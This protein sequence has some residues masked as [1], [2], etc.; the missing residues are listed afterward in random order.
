MKKEEL[1]KELIKLQIKSQYVKYMLLGLFLTGLLLI[2]I[3][4]TLSYYYNNIAFS[5]TETHFKII[6][7]EE[8]EVYGEK[9]EID[10]VLWE[11]KDEF[12]LY[13]KRPALVYLHGFSMNKMFYKEFAH[14]LGRRG[15][16]GLSVSARGHG[17]SSGSFGYNSQNEIFSAVKWLR[18]NADVY[19]IDINR[20]AVVGSSQGAISVTHAAIFDAESGNNWISATIAM[21]GPSYN[22]PEGKVYFSE[23]LFRTSQW[24]Y[25]TIDFNL[26][27]AF[28]LFRL[29]NSQ[30]VNH[31]MVPK[32]YLN[33]I[34]E[35]DPLQSPDSAKELIWYYGQEDLY[36]TSNYKKLE[37]NTRYGSF[38]DGSAR[39]VSLVPGIGH[40]KLASHPYGPTEMIKWVEDAFAINGGEVVIDT[41][42][43][44]HSDRSAGLVQYGII[45]I[46]LPLTIFLGNY[47][48]NKR[49]TSITTK[50]IKKKELFKLFS[51]YGAVFIGTSALVIPVIKTFNLTNIIVVDFLVFN[52]LVLLFFIQSILLLPFLLLLI[53]LEKRKFNEKLKDFGLDPDIHSYL[54]NIVFGVS[55]FFIIYIPLSIL[56]GP[57]ITWNIY[58]VKF[59]SF[60]EAFV[61][62]LV[63]L[64]IIAVFFSG[65][66]QTKLS[67]FEKEKLALIPSLREIIF[68]AG[69]KALFS[70]SAF[71]IIFY[72]FA[73]EN[74]E[75]FFNLLTPLL[76]SP[77]I[78]FFLSFA[79][80]FILGCVSGWL[81]RK[82]RNVLGPAILT[83]LLIS[84]IFASWLP[85]I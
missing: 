78:I 81:Y 70:G 28:D 11:P 37:L 67:R 14:E 68:T 73:R 62:L 48:R 29:E 26:E 41:D 22:V 8:F 72:M 38:D 71:C 1:N 55:I 12:D 6:T 80:F 34:G 5:C 59:L 66:I 15:I 60:I 52:V 58:P 51:V 44:K 3:G 57:F 16:V 2:S 18:D 32:N 82:T 47:A 53:Y 46:I 43:L 21:D 79:V 74:P 24:V 75:A 7:P 20:I 40:T 45:L 36:G 25:P 17:G 50:E 10:S 76:P 56:G 77:L 35:N 83:A 39:K 54:K 30:P 69:I 85:A 64:I 61:Y 33:I 23:L 84:L 31:K 63:A 42:W 4:L 19:N 13:E 27:E 49:S 65:L 9:I